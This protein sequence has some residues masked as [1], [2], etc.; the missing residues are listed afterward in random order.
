MFGLWK[1]KR[2]PV[3]PLPSI[4]PEREAQFITIDRV[5]AALASNDFTEI[6]SL[7]TLFGERDLKIAEGVEKRQNAIVGLTP[8]I[9]AGAKEKKILDALFEQVGHSEWLYALSEGIYYG[10]AMLELDWTAKEGMLLPQELIHHTPTL[11]RYDEKRQEHYIPAKGEKKLY[12]EALWPRLMFYKHVKKG[13]LIQNR[14]LAYKLL[15]YALLKHITIGYNI[16]YFDSLSVPPLIIKSAELSDE[17]QIK[18]LT[19]ALMA[20]KSNS[21]GI[22]PGGIDIDS[23]QVGSQADFLSL[24]EYFDSLIAQYLVGATS[25]SDGKAGSLALA[26]MQNDRFLE[27]ITF[28]AKRIAEGYAQVLNTILS[29]NLPNFTPVTVTLPVQKESTPEEFAGIIK[30]LSD[31]GYE[32][33]TKQIEQKLGVKLTRSTKTEHNQTTK[34]YNHTQSAKTE[35]RALPLSIQ[36][37]ILQEEDLEPLKEEIGAVME[38]LESCA[39]YEEALIAIEQWDNP[40]MEEAL[41][42]LMTNSEIAGMI[43]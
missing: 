3:K 12:T 1:K 22:F 13:D 33:D 31:S 8:V 37:Q 28:D 26:K 25:I 27:K 7:F 38:I 4:T 21:Y 34:S 17:E 15:Y 23:L 43:E 40:K 6:I 10:Y 11:L 2:D 36:E 30:K 42:R 29:L 24:I 41:L 5:K 19:D 9:N 18:A 16:Q 35:G 32:V 14:A 20:L 39:S